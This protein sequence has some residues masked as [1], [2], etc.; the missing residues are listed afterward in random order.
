MKRY[1]PSSY[2]SAARTLL[3][4]GFDAEDVAQSLKRQ[5]SKKKALRLLPDIVQGLRDLHGLEDVSRITVTT[6]KP[7]TAASRTSVMSLIHK[8][9]GAKAQVAEK[10][11]PELLGGFSLQCEDDVTDYSLASLLKNLK[12]FIQN[13]PV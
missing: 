5:L 6:A 9:Y 10:I 7:M 13:T 12:S 1:L 8:T 11:D 2:V 4:S 3:A